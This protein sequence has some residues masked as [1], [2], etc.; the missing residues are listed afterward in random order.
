MLVFQVR[1]IERNAAGH[2]IVKVVEVDSLRMSFGPT[3]TYVVHAPTRLQKTP[4]RVGGKFGPS[5]LKPV[6]CETDKATGWM[7]EQTFSQLA[8]ARKFLNIDTSPKSI[9]A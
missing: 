8:M 1:E 7:V 3:V 2:R 6:V 5:V 4:T 9:A